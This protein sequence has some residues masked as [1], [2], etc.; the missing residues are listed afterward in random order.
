VQVAVPA[1]RLLLPQL[2]LL[3]LPELPAVALHLL[4][5]LL[6]A[7]LNCWASRRRAEPRILIACFNKACGYLSTGNRMW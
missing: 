4:L 1:A 7:D 6:A 2:L 3:L 5:L